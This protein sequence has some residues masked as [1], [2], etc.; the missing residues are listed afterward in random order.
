[1][2]QVTKIECRVVIKLTKEGYILKLL[3]KDWRAYT[4]EVSIP[5][6]LMKK[7]AKRFPISQESLDDVA[8]P[9]WPVEMITEDK[10]TLVGNW[11]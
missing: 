5:I 10:V 7:W 1:M 6:F 8:R 11:N 9:G 4:A 2:S 3:K